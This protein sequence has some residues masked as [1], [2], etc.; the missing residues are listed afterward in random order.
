VTTAVLDFTEIEQALEPGFLDS[1]VL[2]MALPVRS[3]PPLCHEV[4]PQRRPGRLEARWVPDPS[5]EPGLIC[6]WEPRTG[7]AASTP[8]LD[9]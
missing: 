8:S 1:L 6:I 4:R 7:A 3:A 2:E 9:A 5:G